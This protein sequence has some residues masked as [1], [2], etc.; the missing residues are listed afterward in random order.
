VEFQHQRIA[1][2]DEVEDFLTS[3]PTL[4]QVLDFRLSSAVETHARDLLA[5]NRAGTLTPAEHIE[6]DEYVA[7]ENFM[8]RL[9]IKAHL[10]L[11]P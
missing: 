7:L 1:A 6:L 3:S 10:K 4:Q 5:M 8:R 9:K 2:W 11:H